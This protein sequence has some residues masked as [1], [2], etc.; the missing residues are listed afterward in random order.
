VI[1]KRSKKN[2]KKND[3]LKRGHILWKR[4]YYL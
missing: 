2:L 4:K 3:Q 1:G